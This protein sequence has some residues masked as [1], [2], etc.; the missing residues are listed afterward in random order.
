MQLSTHTR[1]EIWIQCKCKSLFDNFMFQMYICYRSTNAPR[2]EQWNGSSHSQQWYKVAYMYI[3][4]CKRK[5]YTKL[6]IFK[7]TSNTMKWEYMNSVSF[8]ESMFCGSFCRC[9]GSRWLQTYSEFYFNA[10][11]SIKSCVSHRNI[12]CS[13]S[14]GSNPNGTKT[15]LSEAV[16]ILSAG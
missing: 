5:L 9:S 1:K 15:F 2:A 8:Q 12:C 11:C 14:S 6:N 4:V 13:P 10:I 7:I 16:S 3:K